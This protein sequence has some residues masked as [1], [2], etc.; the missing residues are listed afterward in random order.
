[1]A[2]SKI[3]QLLE[4]LHQ[5]QTQLEAE[6]QTLL[7]QK[8]AQFKYSLMKGRVTF[9]NEI[10]KLHKAQRVNI[11]I[12]V[13][14]ARLGHLVSAPFI[15][16]LIVPV[17]LLDLAVTSY[18]AICFRIYAIPLVKRRDYIVIDR[19]RLVYLNYI[20]KMNCVYCGY[21]NG[22]LDYAREITART[23]L[24]WCPIKHARLSRASHEM[25]GNFVDYGDAE[26]Y[27]S[28]LESIRK[29]IIEL[30]D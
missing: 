18:Q 1:M 2:Q 13:Y 5:L 26:A 3:D 19:H 17:I 16:S 12:Y 28:N 20:E 9:E 15:Y 4:N 30:Q 10:K 29:Q 23:E 14:T 7:E 22:V 21:G 24:Y 8:Q 11:F 27:R 6:V 25:S